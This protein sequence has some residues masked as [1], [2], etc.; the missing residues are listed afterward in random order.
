MS[1]KNFSGLA[2][3]TDVSFDVKNSVIKGIIGPNGAGKTTLFNIITGVFPPS[4]GTIN[5][6]GNDISHKRSDEIAKLG[7]IQDF[8]TDLFF[9]K[10]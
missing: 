6:D 3:L 7:G 8:S 4:K 1:V 2:A 9:L 10:L 5:F